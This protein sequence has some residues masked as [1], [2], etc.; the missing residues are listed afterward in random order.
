VTL[1][2][3]PALLACVAQAMLA[4]LA[5]RARDPLGAPLALFGA[6]LFV[7]NFADLAFKVSGLPIWHVLDITASPLTPVLGLHFVLLFV[8]RRRELGRV[9]IIL[10][11]LFGALSLSSA[12]ALVTPAHRP[13]LATGTWSTVFLTGTLG[14]VVFG[15]WLLVRY[16][17]STSS[18]D[19][20][21]RARLLLLALPLAAAFGATDIVHILVPAVPELAS[22][23]AAGCAL[24]M[25]IVMLRG[26]LLGRDLTSGIALTAAVL[27]ATAVVAYLLVF[28]IFAAT[29]APLVV[30][31]AT[32]SFAVI[33]AT[34]QLAASSSARRARLSEMALM[35][36][37]SA[38]MAHD[39]KNPLAALKGAAQFLQEEQK[40]G[41]SL[42]DQA[43][44]FEIIVDQADR[45]ER[46]I[47]TYQRIGRLEPELARVDVGALVRDVVALQTFASSATTVRVDLGDDL[48]LCAADRDLLARALENL[49]KN[50]FEAMPEGGALTVTVESPITNESDGDR[51]LIIRIADTG[52]GMNARTRERIFDD[53]YTTKAT[54]SGLGLPF[55]KRVIE[56]HGGD[57]TLTSE[58]GRGSVFTL[59]LPAFRA[60]SA[61][62]RHAHHA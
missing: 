12:V 42:A 25:M 52:A 61:E 62:R 4:L 54:G 58:V 31:T 32:L 40:Q 48:P 20:R 7:W 26:R 44:F 15:G 27:G 35:G 29:T 33:A 8:G 28:R 60:P 16:R 13:L 23:G 50:A 9:M 36:R 37:F 21:T 45:L 47:S 2:H 30:A 14:V 22:L 19:E 53:F 6:D 5:L 43:E 59:Q 24:L 49:V 18:A 3:W 11:G 34:R 38:Q 39:L 1:A 41:R 51:R 10:Y 55:V 56:A 57:V 17:R 46:L